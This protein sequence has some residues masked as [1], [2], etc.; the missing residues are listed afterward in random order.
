MLFRQD[1]KFPSCYI[2]AHL[3]EADKN[4]LRQVI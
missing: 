3:V 4:I 2:V 1:G